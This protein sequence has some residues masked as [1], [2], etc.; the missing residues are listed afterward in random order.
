M[1]CVPQRLFP[2]SLKVWWWSL[3]SFSL[4]LVEEVTLLWKTPEIVTLC[5]SWLHIL[6]RAVSVTDE[7]FSVYLQSFYFHGASLSTHSYAVTSHCLQSSHF[8]N[9]I[10]APWFYWKASCSSR[11]CSIS[12]HTPCSLTALHSGIPPRAPEKLLSWG[13]PKASM[14]PYSVV[15]FLQLLSSCLGLHKSFSI[16]DTTYLVQF[17]WFFSALYDLS[18]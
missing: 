2:P 6:S 4:V 7:S 10:S 15:S 17:F 13:S 16:E 14:L 11:I 9:L 5:E 3:S 1:E 12:F 8:L 18:I